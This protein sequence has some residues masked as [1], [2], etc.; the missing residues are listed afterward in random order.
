MPQL[1]YINYNAFSSNGN[2]SSTISMG[3]LPA[4]EYIHNSAFYGFPGNLTISAGDMPVM[5]T[6]Y[7]SAFY[8]NPNL[9][10]TITFGAMPSL[11]RVHSS[12]FH[13]FKGTLVILAGDVLKMTQI[14]SD[15]FRDA[16]NS[17]SEVTFSKMSSL[18]YV[19]EGRITS[20][21]STV[22]TFYG[23]LGVA[24]LTG[25][26]TS[27]TDPC[28][29]LGVPGT[30]VFAV[31]QVP[32]T[33]MLQ[34][35]IDAGNATAD[36]VTCIARWEFST[37]TEDIFLNEPFPNLTVIGRHA[38]QNYKGLLN[39][40][41]GQPPKWT[42]LG[43]HAF[44]QHSNA[45]S[46]VT[47]GGNMSALKSIGQGAFQQFKGTALLTSLPALEMI[48]G[49]A[50]DDFAGFLQITAGD[51]VNLTSIGPS[52]FRS[53]NQDAIVSIGALPTL[54]NIQSYAFYYFRGT[55]QIAAG[56][57]HQL[58]YVAYRAFAHC[59]N[60][61][62]SVDIGAV[63][64]LQRIE[65]YAFQSFGG[66]LRISANGMPELIYF[67]YA[68]F[69]SFGG[70]MHIA[71]GNL[72]KLIYVGAHAFSSCKNPNSTVSIGAV[73]S[74]ERIE[75]NA[76]D[77][78]GGN[79]QITSGGMQ[80]LSY[81][82][83][84]S[85]YNCNHPDSFVDF[86]DAPSLGRI[87]VHA[88]QYMEGTVHIDAMVSLSYIDDCAFQ[89]FQGTL[90][91]AAGPMPKLTFID[92][93]A[94]YDNPNPNSTI[95][96]GAM[97]ALEIIKRSVFS[98]FSGRLNITAGDVPQLIELAPEC[99]RYA[100][101][102]SSEVTFTNM[103]GLSTVYEAYTFDGFVAVVFVTVVAVFVLSVTVV[104]V[105]VVSVAVVAV[106]VVSVTVVNVVVVVVV[107]VVPLLLVGGAIVVAPSS[108]TDVVASV[109]SILS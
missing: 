73:P 31:G 4:L 84:Y 75:Y 70:A 107:T 72:S 66:T 14:D 33:T 63:P 1:R 18:T 53:C 83:R 27:Y 91:I 81:I 109:V 24:S 54:E 103:T 60:P 95:T 39:F 86:G 62:T 45:D 11:L 22:S 79:L 2:S 69:N 23:F 19:Y 13:A 47:L 98:K 43:R 44:Y 35:A 68:S 16:G 50:F 37:Y 5:H 32:L 26:F 90:H 58:V 88:F 42:E 101:N 6:I 30:T 40:T 87:E 57:M 29:N 105:M 49:H 99:F 64:S 96:L 97:P 100:D 28:A 82:G 34:T 67:G 80:A 52:C 92:Y 78:F 76:F 104:A 65:N 89:F 56:D 106:L 36:E 51:M 74:L 12:A 71:A 55:L 9:A 85:F 21:I 3:A 41:I 10:S 15:A 102:P 8:N 48:E 108:A 94:F 7:S 77:A 20:F 25:P 17:A 46:I 93:K 38:Y 59:N 61:D